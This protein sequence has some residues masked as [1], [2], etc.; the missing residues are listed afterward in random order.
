MRRFLLLIASLTL[1]GF[2]F[3]QTLPDYL[4]PDNRS[5]TIPALYTGDSVFADY[6]GD[7]RPD[8][9]LCGSADGGAPTTVLM[10]NRGSFFQVDF[11]FYKK[12]KKLNETSNQFFI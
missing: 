2:V 11:F 10:E 5:T 3:A 9:F 6:N 12:K 4:T 8:L 1:A 7:G